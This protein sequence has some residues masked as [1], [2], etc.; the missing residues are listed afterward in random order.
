MFIKVYLRN[1]GKRLPFFLI[2]VLGLSMALGFF[3][4][5]FFFLKNELGHDRF[6]DDAG[7]IYRTSV[8]MGFR[9]GMISEGTPF[10]LAESIE[11]EIGGVEMTS[12]LIDLG[13]VEIEL[14]N[15]PSSSRILMASESFFE[16]FNFPSREGDAQ[17]SILD[18]NSIIISSSERD[19]YFKG[20]EAIGQLI[21]IKFSTTN[22][23]IYKIGAVVTD[24]PENSSIQFDMVISSA[25]YRVIH[26][27]QII[28][29]WMPVKSDVLTFAK[30]APE[31]SKAQLVTGLNSIAESHNMDKRLN[32]VEEKEKFPI[33][34]LVDVYYNNNADIAILKAKGIIKYVYVLG[35]GS[36][37]GLVNCHY[38]FC[39][40]I[41]WSCA[42]QSQRNWCSQ[43]TGSNS[44]KASKTVYA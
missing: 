38:Q 16:M 34:R 36:R 19:K 14:E 5:V 39:Q 4:L 40:F 43:G 9:G 17:E 24:P 32:S 7:R 1:I 27:E 20:Q 44:E 29:S 12:H 28:N 42:V 41:C 31:T 8:F 15:N 35:H 25:N 37:V 6:H 11:S 2:N 23:K 21:T 26:P 3:I 18:P 13:S 10:R 30:L 33:M 22:E